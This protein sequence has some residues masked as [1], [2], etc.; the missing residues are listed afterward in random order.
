[1]VGIYHDSVG[2][3]GN[4]LLVYML[5]SKSGLNSTIMDNYFLYSLTISLQT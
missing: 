3:G 5:G 2:H 1:M 4:M